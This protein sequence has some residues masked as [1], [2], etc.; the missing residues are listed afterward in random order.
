VGRINWI[1]ICHRVV[2]IEG[3]YS[4]PAFAMEGENNGEI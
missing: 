4:L 1:D 2:Y 3:V